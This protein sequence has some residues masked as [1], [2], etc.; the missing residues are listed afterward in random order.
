MTSQSAPIRA[1]LIEDNPG[2][3]RLIQETLRDVGEPAP[4]T[5]MH[6]DRLTRGLEALAENPPDVVLL[7]L[8]LPDSAGLDTFSRVHTAFSTIAVVVLS[9]L[10]DE[11]V[12][13]HAVQDGAQDYLVKGQVDGPALVR[14]IRYAV[15]RQLPSRLRRVNTR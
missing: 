10:N 8:S 3:G 4:V 1:L 2:D 14:S 13:V 5:L 9:G 12:A 6:A 11:S 15:E 7:D